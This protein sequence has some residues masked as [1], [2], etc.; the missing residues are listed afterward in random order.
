MSNGTA[1]H[2]DTRQKIINATLLVAAKHG[3]E[4]ATTDE[5]SRT[6]GVSEGIIYHYFRSKQQLYESMVSE[7]AA[8]FRAA[9]IE[10]IGKIRGSRKKLERLIEFHFSSFT[11][12]DSIFR[13]LLGKGGDAPMI[14]D[15]LISLVIMP[16][17]RIISRIIKEGIEAGE[18][19]DIYPSVAALDL[20]GMMQLPAL[21]LH[22]GQADFSA[23]R[24][25]VTVKRLFFG[26]LLK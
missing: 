19:K 24:A 26:G 13:S 23:H 20:I 22:F 5:I 18:F 16:Y 14:K 10:E 1:L 15:H 3:F 6:A 21:S 11:G 17:S 7:K 25:E 2:I 9:L 4:R 8:N 12:K